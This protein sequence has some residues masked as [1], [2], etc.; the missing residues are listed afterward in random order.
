[1]TYENLDV[2]YDLT[3]A[4]HLERIVNNLNYSQILIWLTSSK[5]GKTYSTRFQVLTAA[6]MKF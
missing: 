1:M 3:P 6:S 4:V 2:C 5:L